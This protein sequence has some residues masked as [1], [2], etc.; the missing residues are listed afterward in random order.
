MTSLK[1]E[2]ARE[3]GSK[4]RELRDWLQTQLAAAPPPFYCS[5]DLR[6]SGHK[7]V[8]VDCNLYPAGFNNLCPEDLRTAAA[9][10]RVQMT[11]SAKAAGRGTPGRLLLLPESHTHNPYYT[12]NLFYLL[13]IMNN[14]GF[15]ARLGWYGPLPPEAEKDKMVRLKSESGKELMAW[16]IE[17]SGGVLSA[18]DFVPDLILL[19]NDFSIGYPH[20]LDPVTQPIVPSYTLGWHSRKKSDHFIHYNRLAGEF[21]GIVGIDP[22][23]VQ[24]D[25]E[26]VDPVD[27]NEGVGIEETA[28]SVAR[29]LDRMRQAY[30]DR[31]L[32]R[33]PFAFV[34]SNRG[35]YGMGIVVVRSA[36]ELR[37]MN[38]RVKN[39]MSVGKNRIPIDSVVVQEGVPTATLVDRLPAEPVIYLMGA[40]LVGGFLRTH[41]ERGTEENLNAPGMVFRKLCMSDLQTSEEDAKPQPVLELVYGWVARLSALAAGRELQTRSMVK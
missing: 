41:S 17:I 7:V 29:V 25:T 18:G 40:D 35:T 30:S 5:V 20:G 37:T 16:P 19:N 33:D 2:L 26:I 4:N 28:E 38:R 27:F 14:A 31:K 32:Q 13:Q 11:A 9:T 39:K 10:L 23:T 21:A 36:D 12:E 15:E 8:P 34:K 3:I 6:D 24:L 1:E 22:W